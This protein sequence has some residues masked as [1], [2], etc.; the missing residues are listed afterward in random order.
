MEMKI[1]PKKKRYWG[2]CDECRDRVYINGGPEDQERFARR[3]RPYSLK[4]LEAMRDG[5]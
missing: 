3:W 5:D 4:V 1:L 2:Q